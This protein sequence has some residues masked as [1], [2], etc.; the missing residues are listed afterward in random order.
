MRRVL[1][2]AASLAAVLAV[3][4]TPLGAGE[5]FPNRIDLPDG[6]RPE[7]IATR[8]STFYVGSIP[9]GAVFRGDLRTGQ[10]AILVPGAAGRAAIGLKADHRGRLFVAG[11]PTGQAFVYDA[12][13]GA[14]IASYQLTTDTNTFVNDVV[15]TGD[16]AFFT[17]S[18]R[19]VLYRVPIGRN[20]ALGSA[21]E[22]IPLTG[23]I[24]YTTGFNAN[25]IDA[26]PN[27]RTLII[28]QSNTG[29][30]FAVN[31]SGV[32]REIQLSEPVAFGD[33][34]LLDGKTLYVV[35]NQEN[36]VA[37]VSLGHDFSSGTVVTHLVD[38]GL[39]VP[40]TIAALGPLL[41]AVNARFNTTPEPTT[42]YWITQL[43]KAHGDR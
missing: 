31:H 24:A 20:G 28:V 14:L 6:W 33:G 23:D 19:Q 26:T 21:S 8:G 25:G 40:T 15:V 10:G 42:D 12:Q 37:V 41:Y 27:G 16:G 32:A 34:I 7:G 22:E 36:R 11:G 35:R 5:A 30:L 39:D 18:L 9:T 38:P 4:A 17:D 29:Q 43:E 13:S 3:V 2:L 1:V